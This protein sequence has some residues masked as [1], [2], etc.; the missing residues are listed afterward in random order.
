METK[1]WKESSV[2]FFVSGSQPPSTLAI[3]SL[4][5][6]DH[7][8]EISLG[9]SMRLSPN[10]FMT[11]IIRHG[12]LWAIV[13]SLF[14]SCTWEEV[15]QGGY[16]AMQERQTQLCLENPSRHPAECLKNPPSYDTYQK[17]KETAP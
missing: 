16:N 10:T 9:N 17:Q 6:Y 5:Y 7:I 2:H 11:S 12:L 1:Y 15:K 4:I 3:S 14:I 8:H 13:L